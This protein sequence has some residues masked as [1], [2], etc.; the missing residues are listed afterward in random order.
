VLGP[1]DHVGYLTDDLDAAIA[2]LT[3]L[4]GMQVARPVDLPQYSLAGVF[5]G[6]GSGCVEIF[7]FTEPALLEQRLPRTGTA[8]DHAAHEVKDIDAVAAALSGRGVRFSGPD[9]REEVTEPIVLAGIRH[10]WTIPETCAG[11]SIQILQR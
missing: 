10:L 9:R 3:G 6:D 11:Q 7:T 5:I 1:V 4:L 2:E 8:F